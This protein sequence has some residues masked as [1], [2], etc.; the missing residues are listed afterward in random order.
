MHH[1]FAMKTTTVCLWLP[2]YG[3]LLFYK[4]LATMYM[5]EFENL[6]AVCSKSS[7]VI[8]NTLLLSLKNV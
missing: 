3:Y 4:S 2:T 7:I 5:K 8:I 1:V 6:T